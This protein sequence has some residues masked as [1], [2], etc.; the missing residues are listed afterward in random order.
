N[1]SLAGSKEFNRLRASFNLNVANYDYQNGVDAA[2]GVVDESFQSRT[3]YYETGRLDYA[4]SPATAPFVSFTGRQLAYA[5]QG[6]T[7]GRNGSGGRVLTGLNFEL[8]HLARGEVSF[9]YNKT[10]YSQDSQIEGF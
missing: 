10:R 2:G 3:E 5:S 9:G 6:E 7:Q 1:A 4:L 8:S